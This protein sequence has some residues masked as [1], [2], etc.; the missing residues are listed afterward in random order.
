MENYI[1]EEVPAIYIDG[2]ILGLEV[3]IQGFG[4]EHGYVL[5]VN[6]FPDIEPEDVAEKDID[7]TGYVA[8]LLEGT[9]G[10]EI[11][12]QQIKEKGYIKITE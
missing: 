3:V 5:E 4:G 6:N 12:Y 11:V 8:S 9:N 1:Y 2:S 7:I 10:I